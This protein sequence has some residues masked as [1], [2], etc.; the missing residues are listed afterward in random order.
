MTPCMFSDISECENFK[1]HDG[2][3]VKKYNTP[4]KD[5]KLKNLEYEKFYAAKI[6]C[7]DFEFEIFAYE[8]KDSKSAKKYFENNTGIDTDRNTTFSTS[9]GLSNGSQ[10]VISEEKAYIFYCS[11][12][13]RYDVSDFLYENFTVKLDF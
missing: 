6:S 8:F 10:I 7:D 3:M 11:S 2:V 13:D 5:K 1:K 4:E 9:F 12:S